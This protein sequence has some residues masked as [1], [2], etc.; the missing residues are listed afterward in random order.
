MGPLI[1]RDL[2]LAWRNKIGLVMGPLFFVIFLTFSVIALGGEPDRMPQL[3]E[4]LI[5]LGILLSLFL[6]FPTVFSD[7]FQDGS[8]EAVMLSGVSRLNIAS[9][10]TIT[11]FIL[12]YIPFLVAIPFAG[13]TFGLG[14]E[15]IAAISLSVLFAAPALVIYGVFTGALLGRQSGAGIFAVLIAAPLLIPIFIFGLSAPQSFMT[16]GLQSVEFRALA[17]INLIAIA[18]GLPAIAAVLNANLE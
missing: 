14:A 3:A 11:F 15:R 13:L 4:P 12:T 10:K 17:S 16:S 2:Q 8:M 1:L 5:W 6:Y 9:A 7:D 18:V